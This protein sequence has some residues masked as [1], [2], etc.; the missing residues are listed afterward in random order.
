MDRLAAAPI[1]IALFAD[2]VNASISN[3]WK[4]YG[5]INRSQV[6]RIAIVWFERTWCHEEMA[7][8]IGVADIA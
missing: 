1:Y 7:G 2:T 6:E 5:Q 8:R 4:R 3:S